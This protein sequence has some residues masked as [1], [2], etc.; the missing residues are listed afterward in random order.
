LIGQ[1]LCRRWHARGWEVV[2]LTRSPSAARRSLPELSAAFAWDA[3]RE[4][5]PERA[6]DGVSAVVHLAGEPVTGRWT[7]EKKRR[8]YTSREQGTHHLVDALERL[9]RRP[10]VLVSASAIGY[11][12]DRGDE[13]LSENAAPADDF[14]ARVCK[15]WEAEAVRAAALGIRVAVPRISIVLSADGGALANMLLPFRLGVGGPVGS[16]GQWWSWIH[17]EDLTA[18]IDFLLAR[19]VEGPF[20]LC[21][22]RPVRQADFA[23][24]LGR[25]LRRPAVLPTPAFAV[26]LAL[27]GFA[28]ELLAS[29]HVEP[30]RLLAEEFEFEHETLGPALEDLLTETDDN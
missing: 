25:V 17:I 10:E 14:L 28:Q 5:A 2:A 12:G 26:R 7:A 18:A 3:A 4:T 16:G 22:P 29:K 13:T 21:S 23:R 15:A 19:P 27:G 8:I 24:T 30:A 11:Y 20:N 9:G 1:A 6:F